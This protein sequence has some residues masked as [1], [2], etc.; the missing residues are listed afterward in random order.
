MLD[1]VIDADL[2]NLGYGSGPAVVGGGNE[3]NP[4]RLPTPDQST[5]TSSTVETYWEGGS[6]CMGDRY[7]KKRILC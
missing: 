2:H 5:V 4:Q 3:S 6:I 7:G 1:W